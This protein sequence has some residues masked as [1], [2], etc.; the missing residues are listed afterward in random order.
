MAVPPLPHIASAGWQWRRASA[1]LVC[2]ASHATVGSHLR[3]PRR[4]KKELASGVGER[5]N[6]SP[7]EKSSAAA[8]LDAPERLAN[9]TRDQGMQ[10]IAATE[11]D[12]RE[13][14]LSRLFSKLV[15]FSW[16]PELFTIT[17]LIAPGYLDYRLWSAFFSF[18]SGSAISQ[19]VLSSCQLCNVLRWPVTF[20]CGQTPLV[21]KWACWQTSSKNGGR[22][23]VDREFS[24]TYLVISN[25]I[26]IRRLL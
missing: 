6:A 9:G 20:L 2:W 14:L 22:F 4:I 17:F 1:V 15:A 16:R 26:K 3:P 8:A 5:K 11:S 25:S 13:F 7:R 10:L 21:E 23:C 24:D 18:L 19:F 12:P